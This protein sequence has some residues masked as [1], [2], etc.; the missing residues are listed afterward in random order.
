LTVN[1]EGVVRTGPRSPILDDFGQVG[2]ITLNGLPSRCQSRSI[3]S[4]PH[5]WQRV[6]CLAGSG[7]LSV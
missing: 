5:L 4:A 7:T 3:T 6:L 2:R 1:P